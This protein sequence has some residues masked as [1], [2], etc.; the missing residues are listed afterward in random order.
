MFDK[1]Y[2][3]ERNSCL[4]CST[5]YT[6][7]VTT[8]S[9]TKTPGLAYCVTAALGKCTACQAGFDVKNGKC[10]P[11]KCDIPNALNGWECD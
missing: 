2:G 8:W 11:V 10:V 1:R 6:W 9:C 5:G 3:Y 7:D 4:Q